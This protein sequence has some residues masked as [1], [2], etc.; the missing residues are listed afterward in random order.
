VSPTAVAF[1]ERGERQPSREHL[2]TYV[3]LLNELASAA[4]LSGSV[5]P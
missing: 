1:W 2:S 4:G 3:H 5:K